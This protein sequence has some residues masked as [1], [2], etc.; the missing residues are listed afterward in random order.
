MAALLEDPRHVMPH[1]ARLRV[2]DHDRAAE[3]LDERCEI[4]RRP[5]IRWREFLR[6]TAL[7][8]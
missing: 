1:D 8:H 5:R 4:L 3:L 6:I 7:A 2:R